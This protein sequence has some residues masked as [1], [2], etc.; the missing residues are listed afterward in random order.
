MLK[1]TVI[2]FG[3]NFFFFCCTQSIVFLI[4]HLF[5]FCLVHILQ[6][7]QKKLWNLRNRGNG[8]YKE[9]DFETKKG[10]HGIVNSQ[11]VI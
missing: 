4:P 6:K 11:N 9:C 10:I 8:I 7:E 3:Q 1:N 5:L 2:Y